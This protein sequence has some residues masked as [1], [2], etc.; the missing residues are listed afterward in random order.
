MKVS[1]CWFLFII[2]FDWF[3]QNLFIFNWR[4]IAL[5]YCIGFCHMSAWISHRHTYVPQLLNLPLTS[6][7]V[8]ESWSV[9]IFLL[10][11]LLEIQWHQ[12]ESVCSVYY[13][14]IERGCGGLNW[15]F[16][17]GTG[18]VYI[19]GEGIPN[20][21]VDLI[22]QFTSVLWNIFKCVGSLKCK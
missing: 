9:F 15:G 8:I 18:R 7:P 10:L 22:F 14:C 11:V 17:I 19:S 1:H 6:Y 13:S 20:G 2:D 3:F 21:S 12:Q 5:Q 4:I 16:C